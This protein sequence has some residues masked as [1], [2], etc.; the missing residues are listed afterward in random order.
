MNKSIEPQRRKVRKEHQIFYA[1]YF[2][3]YI[4]MTFF[5]FFAP[6][7][8]KLIFSQLLTLRVLKIEA[9]VPTHD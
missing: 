7:R 9:T 1:I 6:L 2:Q 4:N 8:L 5:A 3:Y